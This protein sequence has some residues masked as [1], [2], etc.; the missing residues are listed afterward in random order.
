[1]LHTLQEDRAR[2][3]A[4]HD[5]QLDRLRL[6]LDGQI[7]K[8]Q[9]AH[10][11][12]VSRDAGTGFCRDLSCCSNDFQTIQ[13]SYFLLQES[14]LRDLADKLEL[15]EKELQGLEVLLQTKVFL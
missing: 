9:L 12:K 6:Q 11:R 10:S 3:Q 1:M 5:L 13:S 4:S 14:E 2:L 15:R 8:T 7:Q